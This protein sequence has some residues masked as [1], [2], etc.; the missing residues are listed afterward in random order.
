V[1]RRPRRG[2]LRLRLGAWCALALL[3]ASCG[4]ESSLDGTQLE[5]EI[6]E[7]LLPGFPEAIRSVSCP[8]PADPVPG[9]QLLCVATLG[10]QVLD[11]NVVIG[12]TEEALTTTATVDARFVAVNEV[13]ALLS[14]TFGEE[15]GLTTSVDCGQPVL[16]LAADESMLCKAT[17]PSGVI[18]SFDVQIADDG[19]LSLRLR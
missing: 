18:R 7:Q 9:Q 8:D 3:A 19:L 1:V 17:D 6:Q 2:V 13:A 5:A 12:G 10:A 4:V 14:A 15:V 16:V 11:V